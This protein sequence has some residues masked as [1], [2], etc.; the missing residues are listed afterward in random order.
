MG[1]IAS[2]HATGLRAAACEVDITDC[3]E[4]S[5]RGV[6]LADCSIHD[7]PRARLLLLSGEAGEMLWISADECSFRRQAHDSIIA[8]IA[9]AGGIPTWRVMLAGNHVHSVHSYQTFSSGLFIKAILPLLPELRANLRRTARLAVRCARTP[10][11]APVI[12]R[13][14][15]F[16][17]LGQH[18][19]MFND[20]CRLDGVR[21]QLDATAQLAAEAQR[22]GSS[23][24]A[25]GLTEAANWTNGPVDDRLHLATILDEGDRPI[26]SIAR[27]NAH[28][29]TASQSR[30]GPV[31]SA[32]YIRPLEDAIRAATDGAPC[33]V[34]N[35]AFGDT[36]PLQR[37]Y[38]VAEAA[39]IGRA[40][41]A[42]MLAMPAD[43]QSLSDANLATSTESLPLRRDVPG[44]RAGLASLRSSLEDEAASAGRAEASP[45]V[46]RQ[47]KLLA[48]RLETIA[49]LQRPPPPEHHGIL[50]HGELERGSVEFRLQAW[51]LGTLRLLACGGEPFALL[52]QSIEESSG[53]LV[54]GVAGAYA[55]YLPD[56]A[57]C[58]GGSYEAAECLFDPAT[59][60]RLPGF[61]AILAKELTA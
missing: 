51:R 45:A 21:G 35:G 48:E 18:C 61:A 40:W 19:C 33:L 10:A 56:P 55:S 11:D 60:T 22:L 8:A 17:F 23:L 20:G 5:Y 3:G 38:S 52:A 54:L 50:L 16:G 42:A 27:V 9:E 6:P 44:D 47:R 49:L 30:V 57:S 14:V 41:A 34:F 53:L 37:E 13:R 4:R 39:R 58:A 26:A 29:V 7:R 15:A 46:A 2:F 32:D 1:S 24:D 43:V 36:R 31:I 25:L 28:P 12:N 59:L